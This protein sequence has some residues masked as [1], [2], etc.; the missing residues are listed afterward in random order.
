MMM[1]SFSCIGLISILWLVYGFTVAFGTDQPIGSTAT[2]S[3]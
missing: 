3:R 1:M 2:T